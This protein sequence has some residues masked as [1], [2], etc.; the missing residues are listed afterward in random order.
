MKTSP[1][2]P[3]LLFTA[4]L[5][6]CHA[7][8]LLAAPPVAP[9]AEA[10]GKT[11]DGTAVEAYTL[12]NQCGMKLRA[13]SYGAIVLSL[14]TPDRA[15]KSADV[16]L[17]YQTLAEYIKDT[18]YFGAIVGRFGNRIAKGKFTLEGKTYTLATNNTPADMPCSLHGGLRGFD[19]VVWQG[20]GLAR[21]GAQ[22]VR[23]RYTSKD[24]E[25][26]YPGNLK[27][28]VTYWLTE[29]SEWQV[30]FEATTDKATPVN[31]TQHSYFNLKGEGRGDIL[32]HELQI[33]ASKFTPVNAG[34]IPTGQI[35][36]VAGTPLDFTKAT[37]IGARIEADHEQLKLGGGY[38]HNWVL[39]SQD[40]KLT[41]AAAVYEPTSGRQLEV[42]TT[43]P[44]IQFYCGNFLDGSLRG[45]AGAAYQK[46][47]GF[48]LETQHYPDSPNHPEFPS[49]I[50]L[51]GK[52]LRS[53]TVFRF[54]TR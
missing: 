4:L 20:E 24:G 51:P 53:T 12:S 39:D 9:K 34:M 18:P 42:L 17:G 22:G 14:E 1:T 15:G 30:E 33:A 23:F 35:L 8:S 29:S 16:V 36:P 31:V 2:T 37:A 28:S 45:K 11:Q 27:L 38:D 52:T 40:G 47:N 21:E 43:E 26:G 48:C 6:L 46:R 54:S 5:A 49:C 13:M 50:L 7:T 41:R 19:K 25:E 3:A 10:F 32:G 44:G